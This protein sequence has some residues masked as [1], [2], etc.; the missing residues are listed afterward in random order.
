NSLDAINLLQDLRLEQYDPNYVKET[1]EDILT[2]ILNLKD[3]VAYRSFIN[4]FSYRNYQSK[5]TNSMLAMRKQAIKIL[6]VSKDE[7]LID[8]Y[9]TYVTLEASLF[10][11][12]HNYHTSIIN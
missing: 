1:W 8:F 11:I 7:N 5:L 12:H 9:D 2:D 3:E 4:L 10:V 6:N